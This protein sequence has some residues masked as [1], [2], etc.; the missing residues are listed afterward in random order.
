MGDGADLGVRWHEVGGRPV[1]V[2]VRGGARAGLLPA[3]LVPGLGSVGSMAHAAEL[4]G[5]QTAVSLLDLPGFGHRRGRAC[6]ATVPAVA[7][8]TAGWLR[9]HA[10]GP[11]VLAGHST[12]A[13][14]VLHAALAV[15]E[16][17]AA[18]VLAGPTFAPAVRRIRPLVRAWAGSTGREPPSGLVAAGP[19]YWRAGPVT[20]ARFVR[21]GLRDRPEDVIGALR[22]PVLL[23]TGA[24]DRFAPPDWI[25]RLAAAAPAARTTTV[26]AS[27]AVPYSRPGQFAELVLTMATV[28]G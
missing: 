6:A 9:A 20:L 23:A 4:V 26:A 7:A 25:G 1:R 19:D 2:L 5:R 28:G 24:Q 14:A 27:H 3:V 10:R 16:A 21:S 18:V 15:P 8:A 12:G 13:Q 11:V 22:C 17:V